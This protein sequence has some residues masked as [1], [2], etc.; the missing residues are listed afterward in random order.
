M[1]SHQFRRAT[2]LHAAMIT[3]AVLATFSTVRADAEETPSPQVVSAGSLPKDCK[4]LGEV[5]VEH[6]DPSPREE[7]A[8]RRAIL[9][10]KGLGATH[11][12]TGNLYA[13]GGHS[14]CYEGTAYRCPAVAPPSQGK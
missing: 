12:V 13:C 8:Q 6:M 11:L 2:R 14:I 7:E 4:S 1:R 3:F 10:A 5:A 9:E